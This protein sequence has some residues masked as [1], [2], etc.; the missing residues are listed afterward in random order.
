MLD[1][2]EL[3]LYQCRQTM[4]RVNMY[5]ITYKLLVFLLKIDIDS[6]RFQVI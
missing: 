3:R 6:R 2:E 4:Q 5:G 1:A